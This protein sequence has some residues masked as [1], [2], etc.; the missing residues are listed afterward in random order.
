MSEQVETIE[1]DERVLV[2]VKVRKDVFKGLNRM[3]RDRD[4]TRTQLVREV[5]TRLVRQAGD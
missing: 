3:A 4:T 2:Q 5:L 1:D